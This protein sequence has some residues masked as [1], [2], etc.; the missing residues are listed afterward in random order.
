MGIAAKIAI[1]EAKENVASLIGSLPDEIYFTSGATESINWAL[2]GIAEKA[3]QSKRH[4]IT[5]SIEHSAVLKACE[6]LESAFGFSIT[7]I[8]PNSNG[9]IEAVEVLKAINPG[10]LI[11]ALQHA[12]NE[13]GT[14]QPIAE[15]G[16]ICRR[17]GVLF[18]VDAAQ[19][20]GKIPCN[21]FEMNIN[22][23][24][25]SG[26]KLYAPKGIGFL[27]IDNE[28]KHLINPLM[29]GGGQESNLRSGTQN[30]PYAIALGEACKICENVMT[31]ENQYTS[32]LR[33]LFIKILKQQFP[34]IIINGTM[35][36]RLP[37]NINFA[38]PGISSDLLLKNLSGI[39]ISKGSACNSG[40]KIQSHV[41]QAI[42]N[43]PLIINSSIRVGIGRFN[44]Q[45]EI[46]SAAN[47]I[48]AT[49]EEIKTSI[50]LF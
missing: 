34:E 48:A 44:T 35:E 16:K 50:E 3:P 19:S 5:S 40:K 47:K 7:R 42:T 2:R 1:T 29:Y 20:V 4:I 17:N 11:V 38:V 37:G 10:T 41:L 21:V 33:N 24:A 22:L 45:L 23:L 25:A 49:I 31:N 36:Q 26:H 6:F 43:D 13:I 28:I 12:N 27:Y 14:I 32:E 46:V 39:S 9:I 15:I 30:V 18:M 8:Q